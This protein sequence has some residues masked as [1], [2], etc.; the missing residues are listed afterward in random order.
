MM[1]TKG[2]DTAARARADSYLPIAVRVYTESGVDVRSD[3]KPAKKRPI[4]ARSPQWPQYV[5]IIDTETTADAV[6][7]LNFG[8][9]RLCTWAKDGRL[10][11]VE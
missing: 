3:G 7:R 5:L 10:I 4:R 1:T 8:C 9:Y 11:C 6:Q 2:H